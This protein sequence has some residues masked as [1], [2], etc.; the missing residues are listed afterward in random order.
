MTVCC[1]IAMTNVEILQ[2]TTQ[3]RPER[4]AWGVL[5]ISFAIFCMFCVGTM[6]GA[7]YFFFESTIPMETVLR[8]ARGTAIIATKSDPAERPVQ[9]GA[10]PLPI[11]TNVS[12][13]RQTQA[14]IVLRDTARNGRSIA[15]ITI[16]RDTTLRMEFSSQPRF[17]WST[18]HYYVNLSNLT[19]EIE[20]LVNDNLPG[21]FQLDI[22]TRRGSRVSLYQSGRYIVNVSNT[23]VRVI[24]R[25]GAAILFASDPQINRSIP[26]SGQG[27][28]NQDL[29]E[30]TLLPGFVDLLVNSA[31]EE[32]N[33]PQSDGQTLPVGWTCINEGEAPS[34]VYRSEILDGRLALRLV[35]ANNASTHGETSCWQSAPAAQ[36]GFDVRQYSYLALR[37]TFYVKYQ[38]LEACG[39]QGSECPLMLKMD[40]R[41]VNGNV[42]QWYHGFYSRLT[43]QQTYPLRCDSCVQEHENIYPA[44]WYTYDSGNMLVEFPPEKKPGWILN[45]QFYASGHQY[46]VYVGELSLLA[47]QLSSSE[48]ASRP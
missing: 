37:A 11:G 30:I 6:L 32:I 34:G 7:H 13:D 22:M 23:H 47:G 40:Y 42:Q 27:F 26:V 25:E 44:T 46:D 2:P 29:N 14:A 35:R 18:S 1:E 33:P 20:V 36:I 9:G 28:L 31:F 17:E 12:T 4:M 24:N 16:K 45:I 3:I 43:S 19:G 39:I 38:S 8:V 15:V 48:T 10:R 5:L 21:N 41:D